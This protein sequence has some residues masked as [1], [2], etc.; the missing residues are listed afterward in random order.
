MIDRLN[1]WLLI[2][3]LAVG[4]GSIT[5]TAVLVSQAN[6]RTDK[7]VCET[8]QGENKQTRDFLAELLADPKTPAAV[9]V[10]VEG[11]ALKHYPIKQC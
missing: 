1:T 11:I 3:A 6:H 8:K 4:L 10:Q 7:Q 5:T 9:R 2:I